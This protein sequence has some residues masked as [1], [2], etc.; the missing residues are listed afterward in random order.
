M[1]DLIYVI[2]TIEAIPGKAEELKQELLKLVALSRQEKGCIYYDL[3]QDRNHPHRMT[4]L[5]CWK[6]REAYDQHNAA[7]FIQEFVE[8]FD[9]VL[10]QNVIEEIYKEV[11]EKAP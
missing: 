4:V 3:Y 7:A 2:E 5:M 1:Q 9:S 10:Y 11:S 6:N 8:E